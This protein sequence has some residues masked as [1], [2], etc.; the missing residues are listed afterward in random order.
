M[1]LPNG[2]D[3]DENGRLPWKDPYGPGQGA[4]ISPVKKLAIAE[5]SAENDDDRTADETSIGSMSYTSDLTSVAAT[6]TNLLPS[7]PLQQGH[8]RPGVNETPI[9]ALTATTETD[10]NS[11]QSGVSYNSEDA[12]GLQLRRGRNR[13]R[14]Q[15]L[16][17][18]TGATFALFMYML[19]PTAL[20]FSMILFGGVS[21]AFFL[22]TGLDSAL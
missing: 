15:G 10:D 20:L 7:T 8:T 6:G 11:I 19:V 9:S 17:A 22:P 1:S 16:G 2:D 3:D 14:L 5:T 12:A 4:D 18:A 21:S 13:R